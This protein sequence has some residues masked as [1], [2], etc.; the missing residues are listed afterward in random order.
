MKSQI[1]SLVVLSLFSQI[2]CAGQWQTGL[3][4]ESGRSILMDEEDK[5]GFVPMVNYVGDRLSMVG[6]TLSYK[7]LTSNGLELSVIGQGRDEGFDADDS[8]AVAGM[9]QREGGFDAG[10]N[11]TVGG[12]WGA[13]Q[14]SMLSDITETSEG[15]ELDLRYGYPLQSGLWTLEPAIG[16]TWKSKQ[17][18]DYYYGVADSEARL[19]RS[20]YQG[21][22]ALNTYA[23]FVVAYK[24]SRQWMLVGGVEV[25]QLDDSIKN[26]PII[27]EDYE[28]TS[29]SAMLYSF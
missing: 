23:E 1:K 10:L 3:V 18:V 22:A 8:N 25:S 17:L 2:V 28:L 9:D 12:L 26:S 15:S 24:L 7:L 5:T 20:A 11:L 16:A 27:D 6:G 13:V 4:V 14:V 19:G 21:E 29:Y